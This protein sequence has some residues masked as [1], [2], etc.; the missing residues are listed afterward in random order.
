[1]ILGRSV[2]HPRR[3][4]P[5]LIIHGAAEYSKTLTLFLI[6]RNSVTRTGFASGERNPVASSACSQYRAGGVVTGGGSRQVRYHWEH[7][8][9][10]SPGLEC[11]RDSRKPPPCG[12]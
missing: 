6:S 5:H 10:A 4:V 9:A 11:V 2:Q 8:G 12:A 1:M 7:G 3:Y